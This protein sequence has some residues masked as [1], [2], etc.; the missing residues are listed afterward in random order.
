LNLLCDK[1]LSDLFFN[2]EHSLSKR[3]KETFSSL[4]VAALILAIEVAFVKP[5]PLLGDARY[6]F[7]MAKDPFTLITPKGYTGWA[8]G[9]R[10]LTPLLVHVLPVDVDEGFKAITTISLLLTSLVLYNF[11]RSFFGFNAMEAILGQILFLTDI[12][13]IYN[14]ANF[15]LVDPLAY[16][17]FIIGL[18]LIYASGNLLFAATMAVAIL[19]KETQ[20]ILAPVY[21]F[22]NRGNGLDYRCLLRTILLSVPAVGCFLA[23]RVLISGRIEE[24]S[25]GASVYADVLNLWQTQTL[26]SI[27]LFIFTWSFLWLLALIGYLKYCRGEK[28]RRLIYLLPLVLALLIPSV[29]I[30]RMLTLAFPTIIVYSLYTISAWSKTRNG[31]ITSMLIVLLHI[32]L[33]AALA[34]FVLPK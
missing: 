9:Y 1:T 32:I 26:R 2:I 30:S 19:N 10:I 21:Y 24:P 8:Y 12:A 15:R 22:V 28:S 7:A 6:Y 14:I 3:T 16:L 34:I 27:G 5:W 23:L 4:L 31:L 17:F 33:Q 18:Y 20:I 25:L 13:V 11:L 29:D